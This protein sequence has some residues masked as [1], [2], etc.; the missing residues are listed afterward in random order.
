M[1]VVIRDRIERYVIGN[2]DDRDERLVYRELGDVSHRLCDSLEAVA[3]YV[4]N[5]SAGRGPKFLRRV[6]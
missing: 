6:K 4:I 2:Y 5:S 3:R 1:R